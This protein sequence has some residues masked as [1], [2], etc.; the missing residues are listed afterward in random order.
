[1]A[2]VDH[3]PDRLLGHVQ[4]FRC[5]R[6]FEK[7]GLEVSCSGSDIR[8]VAVLGGFPAAIFL[9]GDPNNWESVNSRCGPCRGS[10][11]Q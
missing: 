5:F 9:A 6:N 11:G 8:M 3:G 2:P 4:L 1:L 10:N 7:F